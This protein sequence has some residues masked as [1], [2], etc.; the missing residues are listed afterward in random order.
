MTEML[1]EIA[2]LYRDI[3]NM[4]PESEEERAAMIQALDEV[5]DKFEHKLENCIYFLKNTLSDAEAVKLEEERL[6]DKRKKLERK[7][8]SLRAYIEA[9][10]LLANRK[11]ARAGIWKV[12]IGKGG[13]SAIVN[14]ESLIPEEYFN[15]TREIS[16]EKLHEARKAEL[17]VPGV[18]FAM[19]ER[20]VIR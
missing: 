4:S 17:Q 14:D 16:K 19:S 6:Y 13:W 11:D 1:Y 9:M 7:A 3:A 12:K 10:M 5:E 20:M 8:E 2:E 18:T 15:I